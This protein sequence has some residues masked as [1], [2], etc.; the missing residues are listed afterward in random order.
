[1]TSKPNKGRLATAAER[2]HARKW[3]AL[4]QKAELAPERRHC[5][6]PDDLYHEPVFICA[7]DPG[8]LLRLLECFAETG[9]F[10]PKDTLGI[11]GLVLQAEIAQLRKN[12]MVRGGAVQAIADKHN[13]DKRK[14]E[15]LIRRVTDKK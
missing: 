11:N 8:H 2:E 7:D 5:L 3:V 15:R 1:M 10:L 4:Y 12:G 14:V 9:K 6:N 13:L